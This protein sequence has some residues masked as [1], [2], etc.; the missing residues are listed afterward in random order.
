MKR[1]AITILILLPTFLFAQT[2]YYASTTGSAGNPGTLA[3]PWSIDRA[4]DVDADPH[5]VGGDILW[6]RG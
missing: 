4:F 1:I 2:N 6:I 5:P 3:S